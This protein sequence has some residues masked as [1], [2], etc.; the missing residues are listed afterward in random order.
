MGSDWG[1]GVAPGVEGIAAAVGRG[2]TLF[3]AG[4]SLGADPISLEEVGTGL[5]WAATDCTPA[6]C[7]CAMG[8]RGFCVAGAVTDAV[9]TAGAALTGGLP[10]A[11]LKDLRTLGL[12]MSDD[13]M[14]TG[15][16][17]S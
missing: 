15:A 12:A 16:R 5:G 9:G 17:P 14:S 8:R 4:V 13:G 2:A 6:D 11:S 3:V 1:A 7:D 10:M